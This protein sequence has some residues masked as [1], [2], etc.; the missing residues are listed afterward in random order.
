MERFDKVNKFIWNE[1]KLACEKDD[2][3]RI[4]CLFEVTQQLVNDS[5]KHLLDIQNSVH[6]VKF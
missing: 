6:L 2:K 4:Y 3:Q 1:L 5:N